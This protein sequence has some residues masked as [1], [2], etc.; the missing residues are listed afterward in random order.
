MY[1]ILKTKLGWK[2]LFK[3]NKE[4]YS[5]IKNFINT[6]NFKNLAN[7]YFKKQINCLE[8]LF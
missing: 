8:S 2:N 3:P 7:Q 1:N 4:N 6:D 5:Y